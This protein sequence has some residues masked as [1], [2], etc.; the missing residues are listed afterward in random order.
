MLVCEHSGT[1]GRAVV[2]TYADH[3]QPVRIWSDKIDMKVVEKG[4]PS[5]TDC[6][7]G[8]E[9]VGLESWGDCVLAI[10]HSD[11]GTT[12]V[13]LCSDMLISIDS[14]LRLDGDS[15]RAPNRGRVHLSGRSVVAGVVGERHDDNIYVDE[16]K[17]IRILTGRLGRYAWILYGCYGSCKAG[18][19]TCRVCRRLSR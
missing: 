10:G 11:M 7:L 5:L 2:S 4:S 12:V 9:L 1:E 16:Q 15:V 18:S 13:K 17:G 3:Q 6:P 14:I 19:S 8:L